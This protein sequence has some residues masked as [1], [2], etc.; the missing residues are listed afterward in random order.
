MD[1]AKALRDELIVLDGPA[2]WRRAFPGWL[3]LSVY[4]WRGGP[5]FAAA[6]PIDRR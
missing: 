5:S 3:A 2:E 1:L 6:A 4:A